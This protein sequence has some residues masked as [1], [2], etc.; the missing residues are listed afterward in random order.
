MRGTGIIKSIQNKSI[1]IKI[2]IYISYFYLSS[3][4][5]KKGLNLCRII[6]QFWQKCQS[7]S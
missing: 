2:F 3:W 7:R 6:L 1:L 4:G 5:S